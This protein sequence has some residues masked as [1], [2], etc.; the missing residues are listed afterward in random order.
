VAAASNSKALLGINEEEEKEDG[1]M[2]PD[3]KAPS[4]NRR[5][6]TRDSQSRAGYTRNIFLKL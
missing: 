6:E 3:T 4:T 5:M 1:G 2:I